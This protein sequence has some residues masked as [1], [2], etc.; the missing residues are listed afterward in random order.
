VKTI[1]SWIKIIA[2]ALI[3]ENIQ[4]A[5]IQNDKITKGIVALTKSV[6]SHFVGLL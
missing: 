1:K 5:D 3:W 4:L 2:Q 6:E